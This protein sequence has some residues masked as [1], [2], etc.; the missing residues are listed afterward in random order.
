MHVHGCFNIYQLP[1]YPYL[2]DQ[3]SKDSSLTTQLAEQIDVEAG[4]DNVLTRTLRGVFTEDTDCS[5][6]IADLKAGEKTQVARLV[7]DNCQQGH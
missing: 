2:E 5:Q 4:K 1:K 7:A 6:K 3:I